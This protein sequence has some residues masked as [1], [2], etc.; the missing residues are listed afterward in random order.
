M[1]KIPAYLRCEKN[2]WLFV[3]IPLKK[4]PFIHREPQDERSAG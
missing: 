4:P 2:K 3:M 1:K